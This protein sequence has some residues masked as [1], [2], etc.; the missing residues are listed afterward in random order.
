MGINMKVKMVIGVKYDKLPT[1]IINEDGE[2][3]NDKIG[4]TYYSDAYSG[5]WEI[6][7]IELDSSQDSRYEDQDFMW[8]VHSNNFESLTNIAK[9]RLNKIGINLVPSI[10]VFTY[11]T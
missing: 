4:L 3:V 9:Y 1:G 2:L 10:I 6:L 5:N 8:S 7:G 11:Y